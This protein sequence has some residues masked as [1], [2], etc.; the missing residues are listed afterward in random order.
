MERKKNFIALRNLF[1]EL[2]KYFSEV[3]FFSKFSM[4]LDDCC[5][6]VSEQVEVNGSNHDRGTISVSARSNGNHLSGPHFRPFS[7]FAGL[8]LSA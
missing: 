1:L 7:M 4:K 6:R 2:V 5:S 3:F 8:L